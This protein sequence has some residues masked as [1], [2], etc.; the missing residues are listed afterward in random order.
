[1][2]PSFVI[3]NVDSHIDSADIFKAAP[4]LQRQVLEHFAPVWGVFSSIRVTDTAPKPGEWVIELRRLPTMDGALGFHDQQ[5][6]GTPLLYVFPELCE[7]NG[8]SWTSCA[9]HEILET[10]ADPLLRRCV[11][12]SDGDIWALEVCDAVERDTYRIDDVEVSDFCYPQWFEPPKN[13]RGCIFDHL[14]LC[15]RPYEIRIGGYGQTYDSVGR[16]WRQL[17]QMNMYRSTTKNLGFSRGA[18][19]NT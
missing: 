17:G 8:M 16:I 13:L 1:M 4:A 19:R 2:G 10:L 7:Q 14:N 6:D 5:L 12:A 15:T 9:S 18:R 11:Q 3:R